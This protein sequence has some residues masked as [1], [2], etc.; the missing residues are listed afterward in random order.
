MASVC[1][2]RATDH[3][4]RTTKFSLRVPR[5]EAR[6]SKWKTNKNRIKIKQ[7][8][9]ELTLIWYELSRVRGNILNVEKS[10][11]LEKMPLH[12]DVVLKWQRTVQKREIITFYSFC[13]WFLWSLGAADPRIYASRRCIRI[14][15]QML[16]NAEHARRYQKKSCDSFLII[17]SPATFDSQRPEKQKTRR[18]RQCTQLLGRVWHV[19]RQ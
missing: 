19:Q 8:E 7:R 12:P 13:W 2:K 15:L 3:F 5:S 1:D 6:R 10:R 16:V 17:Y 11:R 9:F 4:C 18:C 14:L